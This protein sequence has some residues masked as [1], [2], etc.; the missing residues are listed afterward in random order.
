MTARQ[1]AHLPGSSG[2]LLA[3]RRESPG[4]ILLRRPIETGFGLADVVRS[5]RGDAAPFA[6]AGTWAGG[7]AIVG[8]EPTAWCRSPA[9]L[10]SVLCSAPPAGGAQGNEAV[11]AA[12]VGWLGYGAAEAWHEA[13]PAPGEARRL[14]VCSFA[15]YDHLLRAGPDGRWW[16]EALAT[17]AREG[18]LEERFELVRRRLAQRTPPPAKEAGL[19]VL[20]PLPAPGAH[21]AA[22]ARC[23][24]LIAS[25]DLSQA[26]LCMRLEGDFGGDPLDLFCTAVERLTPPYA[27][28]VVRPEG[29]VVSCSPE[30]F[31][32]RQGRHV[33]SR[34][35]KGTARRTG[36]PAAAE[37]EG[38]ALE[39]SAKNRAEN[40]MIVDLVRN[41]LGRVCT[42]GSIGVPR[43]CSPE[44]HPGLWHLVSEV[45]GELRDDV[46]DDELLRATFPPGSITG[47]PKVRA[48]EVI[49]EL[50]SS[51]REAYTGAI[52]YVSPL[53]GLEL[54]VAIRTFEAS[55]GRVWLGTGGGIV[56]D[57]DPADE[58][59]ECLTKAAPLVEALGGTIAAEALEGVAPLR[60]RAAAGVFTTVRVAGG[61]PLRLDAHLA[62]L[63]DSC[64]R[65]YGKP[66]PGTDAILADA[67][68]AGPHSGR[69]RISVKP[70][71]G[72]L[73]LQAEMSGSGPGPAEV[74]LR[75][76]TVPGGLGCHKWSDRRLLSHLGA[77][78]PPSEE[79]LLVCDA[80]AA[81]LETDRANLVA[82]LDGHLVTP[83]ADGRLLPG[84]GKEVLVGAGFVE[85]GTV[86]LQA[87]AAASEVFVVSALRGAV[88]VTRLDAGSWQASW[89]PG[90]CAAGARRLLERP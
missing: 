4:A 83:P 49:G 17:P 11:G 13:P 66:L 20:A 72:P 16:F 38:Q 24:E 84:I 46:D 41:D 52:G 5:V 57:S 79:Q 27:A 35:I 76:V 32:R 78:P 59:A 14:P 58:L 54:N 9:E 85:E 86:S 37:E 15:Y 70:V 88:P 50:E 74:S 43:L 12:W 75:A 81:C 25:G 71:G 6:L 65:L 36:S 21:A 68:A 64:R 33:L 3:P 51:P 10:R 90:P 60:P 69:L 23:V 67:L 89:R 26:N 53:A 34:P 61:V 48:M 77:T 31:L 40:V 39:G 55:G 56:A 8:A 80:D 29:S 2:P 47:A 44:P 22:V 28:V 1:V 19:G 18:P 73:R 87:L 42:P 82:L 63:G 30:L 45:A 7:G 62:R